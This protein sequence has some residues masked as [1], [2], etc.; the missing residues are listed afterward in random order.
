MAHLRKGADGHLLKNADG[1]LVKNCE[2]AD[3]TY[4]DID[5]Y[6]Y[7]IV[8]S[9]LAL[10][11]G[12]VYLSGSYS[13]QIITPPL[14]INGT[15]IVTQVPGF[16]C[17]WRYQADE[18]NLGSISICTS[19]DCS[20]PCSS[21]TMLT[22]SVRIDK[23]SLT[24]WLVDYRVYGGGKVLRLFNREAGSGGAIYVPSGNCESFADN[25]GITAC[26]ANTTTIWGATGG[27]I[28]V[29]PI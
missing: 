5:H 12:C 11:A 9:D 24:T 29:T 10:C 19:S 15:W 20:A 14:T 4:C 17:I 23:T 22:R 6:E 2:G 3:C 1:H 21:A 13:G 26:H 8:I 18:D 25:N 28:T 7:E 27:T 16:P